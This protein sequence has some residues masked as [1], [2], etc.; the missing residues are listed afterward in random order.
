[1]QILPSAAFSAMQP[2]E[3]SISK[4]QDMFYLYT[5]FMYMICK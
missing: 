1:M 3:G 5:N 4:K 2:G